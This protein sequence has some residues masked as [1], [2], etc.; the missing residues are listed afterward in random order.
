[1]IQQ[2][3]IRQ[4]LKE[5]IKSSGLT[6]KEIANRAG[7]IQQAIAQYIS[8]RAMPS[9]ETFA[10]ICKELDLDANEILCITDKSGKG[11]SFEYEHN[12]TKLV[13]KE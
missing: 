12:K 13:H 5:A 8:G 6:Q 11:Y 10:N 9:I 1:M 3:Q 4:K 2:E 7:V